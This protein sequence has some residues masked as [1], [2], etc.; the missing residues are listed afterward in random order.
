[1]TAKVNLKDSYIIYVMSFQ[2][3]MS[4]FQTEIMKHCSED[5]LNDDLI[6]KNDASIINM[7]DMI[8][9]LYSKSSIDI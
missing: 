9:V 2:S 1:M 7:V 8:C 6:F 3:C 5:H 4:V